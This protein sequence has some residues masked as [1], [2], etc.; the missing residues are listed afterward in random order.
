M[1]DFTVDWEY[2]IAPNNNFVYISP[3]CHEISGY[4]P[5][6]FI[7]DPTLLTKIICSVPQLMSVLLTEFLSSGSG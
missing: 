1:A 3:S 4:S 7:V 5:E 2:W 6:E